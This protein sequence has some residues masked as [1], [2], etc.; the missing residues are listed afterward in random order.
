M[1]MLKGIKE[2]HGKI[3]ELEGLK[4]DLINSN[5][6]NVNATLITINLYSTHIRALKWVLGDN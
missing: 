2:I 1:G 5:P 6:I 4:K 3:Q